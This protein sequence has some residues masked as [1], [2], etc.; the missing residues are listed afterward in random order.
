MLVAGEEKY[1]LG[2]DGFQSEALGIASIV[3]LY[4]TQP[5]DAELDLLVM[6]SRQFRRLGFRCLLLTSSHTYKSPSCLDNYRTE[7]MVLFTH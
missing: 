4:S 6:Y 1:L 2:K 5:F 7:M 3:I